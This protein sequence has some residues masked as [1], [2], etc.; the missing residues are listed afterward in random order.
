MKRSWT[1]TK[2]GR[3]ERTWNTLELAHGFLGLVCNR[4]QNGKQQKM[5]LD[6]GHYVK[7]FRFSLKP[8]GS[9]QST[10]SNGDKRKHG[11][12]KITTQLA[13]KKIY[14][15]WILKGEWESSVETLR[16]VQVSNEDQPK[17]TVM[18]EERRDLKDWGWRIDIIWLPIESGGS[19]IGTKDAK[20]FRLQYGATGRKRATL[21]IR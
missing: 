20:E 11:L 3:W 2:A 21:L 18:V 1:G 14:L 15:G 7:G 9:H 19:G 4:I 8:V 6:M 12:Q 16:V 13:M 17:K 5:R 10:S